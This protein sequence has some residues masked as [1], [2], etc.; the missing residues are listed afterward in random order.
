MAVAVLT[1][2]SAATL[3]GLEL[4]GRE[5]NGAH[6]EPVFV[7]P[8][9][10]NTFRDEELGIEFEY[11]MDWSPEVVDPGVQ[12]CSGCIVLGPLQPPTTH[13][14]RVYEL[15]RPERCWPC[16]AGNGHRTIVQ[17]E[18]LLINGYEAKQFRMIANLPVGFA[19]QDPSRHSLDQEVYTGFPFRD[20][21]IFIVAFYP[22]GNAAAEAETL[23]AYEMILGSVRLSRE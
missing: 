5:G 8:F 15:V 14:I 18:S 23:A 16:A 4:E 9:D 13:G 20:D 19:N 12:P 22:D 2:L 6:D 21:A 17:T 3:I 7:G 1:A 10:A 11:P